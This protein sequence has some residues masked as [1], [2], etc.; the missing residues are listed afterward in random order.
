[1]TSTKETTRRARK[2]AFAINAHM[3]DEYQKAL[4]EEEERVF[5]TV[6]LRRKLEERTILIVG[7]A[8]Y[9]GSVLTGHFLS[10]GYRVRSFDNLIFNNELTIPPY[11]PHPKYEFLRG[12]L[13]DENEFS[14]ALDGVTDV[15]LLAGL[16][17]DPITKKFPEAAARIN[18]E[19][20]DTVIRL[21][22]GRGL[23]K[24]VFVSTCSNY[25]LIEGDRL[26]DEDFEL[27]P[28]SLYA[29]SKVRV[30][31]KFLALKGKVDY[32]PTILRFATAFGLSS[33]MRF[34]LTVSEFTRSMFLGE[35]LLVYDAQTWRPYCHVQ[36]FAEVI[37]RVLEAPLERVSFEIFNAGSDNNNFTKQMIV[38]AILEQ[39]SDAKVRYQEHGSDPRNYRVSF[40]KIKDLL[41]FEPRHTV[42]GGIREL[43][44]AMKQG[45]FK[46]ISAPKSFYGNWEVDYSA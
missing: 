15:V 40:A 28:L 18:D 13:A 24:V 46:D 32:A 14:G 3:P 42:P 1:M 31:N 19:G 2:V 8:G 45:L 44:D 20:H 38:D 25:G 39:L 5:E 26:A 17:G 35:D 27:K 4:L 12:D 7:G 16:V 9:I 23:N 33:R 30:E 36:D 34:D 6:L 11:L 21:L 29:K 43:I 22:N 37:R 41:L 10:R